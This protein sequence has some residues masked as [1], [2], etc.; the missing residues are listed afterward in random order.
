MSTTVCTDPPRTVP[1]N[2]NTNI[3]LRFPLKGQFIQKF[4]IIYPPSYHSK[5]VWVS[6]LC[7]TQK[8]IFWRM[9]VI[10]QLSSIVFLSLLWK[11]MGT[12]NCL[13]L[14]NIFFCV[15]HKRN[16]YRFVMTWGW[17]NYDTIFILGRTVP[18]SYEVIFECSLN[19]QNVQF[20]NVF[21]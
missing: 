20:L 17:V 15:Q 6:F 16:L 8:K 9:L 2:K 7:W 18:L 19:I 21:S 10:K 13:V 11:S 12:K 14:Q 3:L 4:V 5:P 1:A